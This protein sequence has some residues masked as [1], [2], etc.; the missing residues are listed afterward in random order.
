LLIAHGCQFGYRSTIQPVGPLAPVANVFI[1]L[2]N[3]PSSEDCAASTLTPSSLVATLLAD[4]PPRPVCAYPPSW[5]SPPPAAAARSTCR[6][7]LPK[8]PQSHWRPNKYTYTVKTAS[9]TVTR[10]CRQTWSAHRLPLFQHV[11]PLNILYCTVTRVAERLETPRM[12]DELAV[13]TKTGVE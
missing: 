11:V 4:V 10:T 8:P 7:G 3:E 12:G 6:D 5:R 2:S 13:L 1:W 9:R